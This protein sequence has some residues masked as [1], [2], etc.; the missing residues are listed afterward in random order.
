MR[1]TCEWIVVVTALLVAGMASLAARGELIYNRSD[2]FSG[3]AAQITWSRCEVEAL[4][5]EP[6]L[7]V[8]A[9][10]DIVRADPNAIRALINE[11]SVCAV[12]G[13][14][15]ET[16][17]WL[18]A[19]ENLSQQE[20]RRCSLCGRKETRCMSRWSEVQYASDDEAYELLMLHDGDDAEVYLQVDTDGGLAWGNEA[21][22]READR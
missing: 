15:W 14:H 1:H 2:M 3:A 17:P 8:Q 22:D 18:Y 20:T 12:V 9:A 16:V 13:H 6:C 4:A 10:M 5:S 11:G 21:A 7:T 19:M